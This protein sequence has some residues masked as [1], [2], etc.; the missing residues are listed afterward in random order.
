MKTKYHDS[1]AFLHIRNQQ[2]DYKDIESQDIAFSQTAH[3][4][5]F[6]Q[7]QNGSQKKTSSY[8]DEKEFLKH[9]REL[10]EIFRKENE[11]KSKIF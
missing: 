1:K 8:D 9:S 2:N 5:E 11:S 7:R 6:S 4:E 10:D 3:W